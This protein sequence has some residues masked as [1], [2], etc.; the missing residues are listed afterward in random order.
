MLKNKLPHNCLWFLV[1]YIVLWLG[2]LLLGGG[3]VIIMAGF[4]LGFRTLVSYWPP[5]MNFVS[6][7]MGYKGTTEFPMKLLTGWRAV[8]FVIRLVMSV[9]F[10]GIGI[11]I[12]FRTGFLGQNLIYLFL[13]ESR[14]IK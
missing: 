14:A 7:F 8:R 10:I 6:T 12:I 5:T 2:A 3:F 13:N 9:L 11:Y 4:S 1:L